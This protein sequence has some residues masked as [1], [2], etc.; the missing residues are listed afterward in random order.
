MN[1]EIEI[2]IDLQRYWDN[3]LRAATE[4]EKAE[5]SIRKWSGKLDDMKKNFAAMENE[6]KNIKMEIKQ[7]EIDLAEKDEKAK[8]L[9]SRRNNLKTE[10]EVAALKKELE[11]LNSGRG[12]LEEKLI[13]LFDNLEQKQTEHKK[14]ESELSGL[15]KDALEQI[16]NLEERAAN[17]KNS[18]NENKTKFDG[19]IGQLPQAV[20]SRFVRHTQSGNGKGIAAID[21]LDICGGCNFKI[22]AH[23][24][25]EASK[26]EKIVNCTNCGRFIYRDV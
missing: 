21:R 15:T 26:N 17:F 18:H 5:V 4:I 22:P 16:N 1:K 24:A 20:S 12:T 23:L 9:E 13:D 25:Q 2:M 10:K 11:N 8:K 6:I 7:N 3:V 19:L 14:I